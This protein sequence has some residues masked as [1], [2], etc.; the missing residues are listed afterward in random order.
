MAHTDST[1][2]EAAT[3]NTGKKVCGLSRREFVKYTAGSAAFLYFGAMETGCAS[4]GAGT[5]PVEYLIA[6]NVTTTAQ[7]VLSF[8][9][10]L[11]PSGP[12]SSTGLYKT[13][14]SQIA[15]YSK[16]SYGSYTLGS[17]LA[18]AKRFDIMPAGYSNT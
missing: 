6:S 8:P 18:V 4:T 2:K 12:N 11:M 13:E 7:Q 14:L 16:F 5:S 1:N 3:D 17:G 15:Q 9:V 10:P